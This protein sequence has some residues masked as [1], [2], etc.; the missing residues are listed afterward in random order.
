MFNSSTIKTSPAAKAF[1]SEDQPSLFDV[2]ADTSAT[3]DTSVDPLTDL[4]AEP[5]HP[6]GQQFTVEVIR[7][8]KRKKSAQARLVGNVLEVRVPAWI[9]AKQEADFVTHFTEKFERERSTERIN[10]AERAAHLAKIHDLPVPDEIR[11]VSNQKQRWG[12]CTPQ[13]RTIRLSDRL[14]SFPTWVIDYVIVHELAHLVELGHTEAFWALT[15]RY[16]LTERARGF[17]IAKS[18]GDDDDR[19]S[20]AE[21]V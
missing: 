11:W 17:L 1:V 12:S 16:P 20:V 2:L 19:P 3:A 5:E 10:L 4:Q 9:S 8:A 13:D 18:W 14:A 6:G 15:N 21:P 7:S